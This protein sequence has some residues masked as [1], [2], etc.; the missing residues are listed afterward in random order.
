MSERGVS[1]GFSSKTK[2]IVSPASNPLYC[3]PFWGG[4]ATAISEYKL[5]KNQDAGWNVGLKSSVS[6]VT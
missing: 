3:D 5:G 2:R 1:T 6:S 4:L